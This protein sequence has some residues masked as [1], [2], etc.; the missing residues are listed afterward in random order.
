[1]NI[2]AY[3]GLNRHSA[4]ESVTSGNDPLKVGKLYTIDVT[5]GMLL[6]AYPE[7]DTDTDF[8]FEYW[9]GLYSVS[10]VGYVIGG[11]MFVVFIAFGFITISKRMK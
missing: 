9:V 5:K 6:V 3:G 11:L 4:T 10:Y 7:S 2:Y 8:E 1:M